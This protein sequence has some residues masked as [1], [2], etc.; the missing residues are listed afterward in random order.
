MNS[1]WGEIFIERWGL[2]KVNN[3]LK[4]KKE[5]RKRCFVFRR[6]IVVC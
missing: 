3:R 1:F 2:I 6:F 5:K 4:R